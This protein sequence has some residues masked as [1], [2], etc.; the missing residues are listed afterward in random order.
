MVVDLGLVVAVGDDV[1][2]GQTHL[3]GNFGD[4]AQGRFLCNLD[5]RLH[6]MFSFADKQKGQHCAALP[7][8]AAQTVG[9]D[10]CSVRMW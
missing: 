9:F 8:K 2:A 4:G 6:S 7:R 10:E 1:L 5:V 3:G